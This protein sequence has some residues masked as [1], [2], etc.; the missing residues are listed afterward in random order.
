MYWFE[1]VL[2]TFLYLMSWIS[3][4]YG[5]LQILSTLLHLVHFCPLIAICFNFPSADNLL[6]LLFVSGRLVYV[7][8]QNI[9]FFKKLI[10]LQKLKQLGRFAP[11]HKNKKHAMCWKIYYIFNCILVLAENLSKWVSLITIRESQTH[12]HKVS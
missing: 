10:T 11:E 1:S 4:F 3:I 6:R 7:I 5:H 2:S 8:V 12:D 9:T